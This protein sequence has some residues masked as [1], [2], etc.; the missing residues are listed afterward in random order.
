M[1][2]SERNFFSNNRPCIHLF[3]P[4]SK[5]LTIC[6]YRP[7]QLACYESKK[8]YPL[9]NNCQC[10]EHVYV[11]PRFFIGNG[12]WR[13]IEAVFA[14]TVIAL[15]PLST[16]I[17]IFHSVKKL[18]NIMQVEAL[19]SPGSTVMIKRIYSLCY[20][21]KEKALQHQEL[22]RSFSLALLDLLTADK[23]PGRKSNRRSVQ[24]FYFCNPFKFR[25]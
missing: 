22:L 15:N 19:T 21:N 24:Q 16:V 20:G 1:Y 9:S 8:W 5:K 12:Q 14:N 23:V 25:F 4:A 3:K 11:L 7:R 6:Y 2:I 17:R 10:I 13:Q 18:G